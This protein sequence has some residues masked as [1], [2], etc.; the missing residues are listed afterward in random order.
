MHI[1]LFGG[2]FDPPHNGH[3]AIAREILASQKQIDEVWFLPDNQHQWNP[4]LASA[5]DRIKMLQ[6]MLEPRMRI[7]TMAVVL[8]GMTETLTVVRKL[9]EKYNHTFVF[10]CGSDQIPTFPKWTHWEELQK[11]LQFLIIARKGYPVAMLP[12][13]CMLLEDA[14]YTP[15]DDSATEIRNRIKNS[16]PI[17]DLVPRK[18]EEYIIQEKLYK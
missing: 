13:N 6:Q 4:I 5:Q 12:K 14:N 2:R 3:L 16:K 18:V 7:E 8:G 9:R 11:E 1:A 17:T 10:I 15:L